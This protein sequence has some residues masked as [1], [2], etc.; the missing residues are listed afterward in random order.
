MEESGA[1]A[2]R[3]RG[4]GG[5]TRLVACAPPRNNRRGDDDAAAGFDA[6][7]N[8]EENNVIIF[9]LSPE[10]LSVKSGMEGSRYGTYCTLLYH[11]GS[12]YYCTTYVV[13]SFRYYFYR[14]M[15]RKY[16]IKYYST[17]L[18]TYVSV[19]GLTPM[20]PTRRPAPRPAAAHTLSPRREN[21]S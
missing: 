4:C 21:T 15:V 1:A 12:I 17:Y 20:A 6:I 14:I 16:V 3:Q 7:N 2:A 18:R 8:P 11:R 19:S 9:I 5:I 13:S 10:M